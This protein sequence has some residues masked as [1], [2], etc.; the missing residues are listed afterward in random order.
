M[1]HMPLLS[2]PIVST[3][4][5]GRGLSDNEDFH[6]PSVMRRRSLPTEQK[7]AW[8]IHESQATASRL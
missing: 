2:E 1:M 5:T 3:V 6:I 8:A 4:V 7:K